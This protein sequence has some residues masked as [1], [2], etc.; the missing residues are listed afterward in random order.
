MT[1]VEIL[2][3]RVDLPVQV[4]EARAAAAT[5]VV[6]RDPVRGLLDGTGLEPVRLPGARTLC[7]IAAVQYVDSDLGRYNEVA[8]AFA[9]PRVDG[10]PGGAFI[11]QLPVDGEFTLAAGRGIWGFPKWMARI[12]LRF[13]GNG[14]R[15][16]L[17]ADDD[18]VLELQVASRR[19]RVPARASEMS[20]YS[21]IDGVTR[22]TPFTSDPSG[23]RIRPGGARLVLGDRHPLA[24]QLCSIG[25][26]GRA[27]MSSTIDNLAATFGPAQTPR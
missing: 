7:V 14:A 18:L 27:V 26:R 25:L 9:V 6:R 2:G 21:R 3:R 19:V 16:R 5:F 13:E 4:R 10:V 17:A 22:R 1:G 11:H 23:V 15:C 12:D 20:A 8:V 24:R